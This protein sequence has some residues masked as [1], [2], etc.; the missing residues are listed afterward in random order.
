[1]KRLVILVFIVVSGIRLHAQIKTH[2]YRDLEFDRYMFV[3]KQWVVVYSPDTTSFYTFGYTYI[4]PDEGFVFQKVGSFEIDKTNRYLLNKADTQKKFEREYVLRQI[5]WQI[6]N[7]HKI[8]VAILPVKHYKEL[9][10]SMSEPDWIQTYYRYTDTLAYQYKRA[11]VFGEMGCIQCS[12]PYLEAVY[13]ADPHYAGVDVRSDKLSGPYFN[14]KGVELMLAGAY[15]QSQEFDKAINVLD[16]AIAYN[17][18]NVNFYAALGGL[19]DR[20]KD[21]VMAIDAYKR[22]IALVN[23]EKSRQKYWFAGCISNMYGELKDDEQRKYWR[24]KSEEYNPTPGL[25]Y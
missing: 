1:M 12:M 3:E 18:K 21:W 9:G 4:D 11:C 5:S 19:H 16:A 14:A 7:Y 15:S 10:I 23:S 8:L 22:G 25:M 17:P 2:R 13:K 24:A 6:P 20:K